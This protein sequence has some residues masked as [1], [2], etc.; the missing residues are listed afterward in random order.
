MESDEIRAA[1]READLAE[2]A[3][4]TDYPPTP[5][6]YPPATGLWAALL[7]LTIG[8]LHGMVAALALLALMAAELGF[9]GWYLRYRGGVWQTGR[10]P[11]E[12]HRAIGL[13][14]GATALLVA[15]VF[16]ASLTLGPWAG[17]V[18]ALIGATAVV[19]W[20]ERLYAD[21]ARRTRERL[22]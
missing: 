13:F 2:A 16:T 7:T 1:L 10:P 18:L 14:L 21:A 8:L 22:A 5:R 11:R 15:V 20:Y 19:A 9:L 6:W 3:P 4:W 12:F 17:A